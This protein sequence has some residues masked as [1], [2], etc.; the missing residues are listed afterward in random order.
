MATRMELCKAADGTWGYVVR[1]YHTHAV[2]SSQ[3]GFATRRAAVRHAV[4]G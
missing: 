2:V 4:G 1:D 3:G